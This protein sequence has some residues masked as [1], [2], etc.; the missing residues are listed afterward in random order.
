MKSSLAPV[1]S[2][3]CRPSLLSS[4]KIASLLLMAGA[5]LALAGSAS[6]Q[7]FKVTA[8]GTIISIS[9]DGTGYFDSSVAVGTPFTDTFFF[10]Y[11]VVNYG[12]DS[13]AEFAVSS[14]VP[15][16]ETIGND[17]SYGN[18]HFLPDNSS[19]GLENLTVIVN[20]SGSH[21]V[22]LYTLTPFI[23][24]VSTPYSYG[25]TSLVFRDVPG[26]YDVA[27]NALPPLDFYRHFPLSQIYIS[28]AI[29]GQDST[30][31]DSR[32]SSVLGTV[33]SITAEL[34][35]PVP[36]ASTTVSFGLLLALGLGGVM[37][38]AR[39]RKA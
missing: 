10:D 36:E 39:R 18:Y 16:S 24:G 32:K 13:I 37:V 20:G 3:S 21:D 14:S 33:T 29:I 15:A 31:G 22:Y 6:A 5:S 25:D 19:H 4:P 27:S 35:N 17:V 30:T 12:S 28:S 38:A 7:Q 26:V 2:C 9:N 23:N 34:V 8:T 11:S 1:V